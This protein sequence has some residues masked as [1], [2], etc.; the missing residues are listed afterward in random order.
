MTNRE[1][2]WDGNLI[3]SSYKIADKLEEHLRNPIPSDKPLIISSFVNINNLEDTSTF[4]RIVAEQI[5]SRF[6]QKGY[7]IIEMK[8]RNKSIFVDKGNGEFML[9]RDLRNISIKHEAFAVI[10]GTYAIGHNRFYISARIVNPMNNIILSS[11][12]ASVRMF[13]E[14]Q[15]ILLRDD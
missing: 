11:S 4:G 7:T 2:V 15:E 3:N 5:G 13:E 10:V 1:L 9:S 12:D 6:A 14:K 8:L